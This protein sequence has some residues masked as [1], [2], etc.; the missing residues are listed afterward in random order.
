[1][2]RLYTLALSFLAAGLLLAA[3][4]DLTK[5]DIPFDITF[6]R[7]LHVQGQSA[8]VNISDTVNLNTI[9]SEFEKHKSSLSKAGLYRSKLF[10]RY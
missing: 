1:M 9:S 5:I 3:C 7:S 8:A 10:P 2:K 6:E 4:D